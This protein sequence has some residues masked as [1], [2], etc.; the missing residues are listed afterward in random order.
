LK[1]TCILPHKKFEIRSTKSETN[2]KP[3]IQNE[4]DPSKGMLKSF[5]SIAPV[6]G[7]WNI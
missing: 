4:Q 3:K 1:V 7:V 6:N 5:T 2:S